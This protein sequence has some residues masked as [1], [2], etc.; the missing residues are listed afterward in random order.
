MVEKSRDVPPS[1]QPKSGDIGFD[2]DR[3]LESIVTVQST[4]PVDA[5]TAQI[6]GTERAGSG[7]VIGESGLVLTIGYLVTEA[8]TVW[9]R[10][11]SGP[12]VTGHPLATDQETGFARVQALGALNLP[13]LAFASARAVSVGDPVVMIGGGGG[14]KQS[15]RARIVAKQEFSGYWEYLL[16]EAIFTAPAH[17][18]W[19]GAGLIGQDGK[20]LGVGSLLVQQVTETGA[21][22]DLNMI[23]PI[24]L[25]PPIL[26]D[27]L[28]YGQVN[29]PPRPWV[30]LYS[31]ERQ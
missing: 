16:D 23:V 4:I 19:G 5:F 17:P 20:L 7:V 24:D 10:G 6:L 28:T 1:L 3:A 14:R 2:L 30:G 22:Q 31:A 26:N 12:P 9:L 27:L 21:A 25:L 29:K 18:L 13:A 8:E 11:A 15:V